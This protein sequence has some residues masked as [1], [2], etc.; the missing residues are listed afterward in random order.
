VKTYV[1]F[2][3][4]CK[5][6]KGIKLNW[7]KIFN[8]KRNVIFMLVF[9]SILGFLTSCGG[10]AGVGYA[11]DVIPNGRKVSVV[12]SSTNILGFTPPKDTYEVIESLVKKCDKESN[13]T[14][15]GIGYQVVVRNYIF[16]YKI[17]IIASG[18]CCCD[19]GGSGSASSD[20]ED[21]TDSKGKKKKK[22]K[23]R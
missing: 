14:V 17:E 6:V 7:Q 15:S 9:A 10:L 8:M 21:D 11:G 16:A 20:D 22:G 19:E 23:G 3:K 13:G 2:Y 12:Y 18:Y 1:N 4:F 5:N